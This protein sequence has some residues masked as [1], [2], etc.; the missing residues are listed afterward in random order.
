VALFENRHGAAPTYGLALLFLVSFFNYLDRMVLAVMVEPMKHDLE[1]TD[2]QLGLVSGLAFAVLYATM[3]LPLA[4]IADRGSRKWLLAICLAAW[5][6]MTAI[7]GLARNFSGLFLARMGVG[8]GEAGCVP[9]SHSMI[10]DMFTPEKRALAIGIFQAG[11]LLGM[12]VG[13][14]A[15][16]LAA[17]TYGWRA[18]LIGVGLLGLPLA[19]LLA[20]TMREPPRAGSVRIR[21]TTAVTMVA[22][23]RRR[24][25]VHLIIG[26]SIGSFASYGITQWLPAF[27]IRSHQLSLAEVGLW[28]GLVG[29]LAGILGA[30]GGGA[31][32]IRLQPR[33][34]RWELWLP[35]IAYLACIPFYLNAFYVESAVAAYAI[36]AVGIA[37]AAAGGGVA[38]AAI[39]SHAEPHRRATAVA[40]MMFL[41]SLI[42]LGLGPTVVGAI[43]D[44]LAAEFGDESLRYALMIS[45][46]FLAWSALHFVIAARAMTFPDQEGHSDAIA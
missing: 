10:G 32:M 45:T 9:A 15:A 4:R 21:E 13:L 12:S 6:A 41:S 38:I 18:A 8:I 17:E 7:T 26:I 33:D 14:A 31:L 36:K 39:Q 5:S 1:L 24:P 46:G 44:G 29:G 25:L 40:V 22:L 34:A 37:V 11:G 19:L 23:A 2:T 30:V 3:G 43:S 42:G 28:G 16:G 27:F 20:L 35:C